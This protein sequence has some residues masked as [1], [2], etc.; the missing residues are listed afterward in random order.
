[1]DSFQSSPSY[2]DSDDSKAQIQHERQFVL[3]MIVHKYKPN[4]TYILVK[5]E[6]TVNKNNNIVLGLITTIIF[7]HF[8]IENLM[9]QTPRYTYMQQVLPGLF[10]GSAV[11]AHRLLANELSKA[12][13]ADI[14][15]VGKTNSNRKDRCP[16][17]RYHFVELKDQKNE[18][19]TVCFRRCF[20][21]MDKR[22]N[23]KNKRILIHCERGVSRSPSIVMAYLIQSKVVDSFEQALEYI[24]AIRPKV[25]PLQEFRNQIIEWDKNREY[26]NKQNIN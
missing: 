18:D 22:L 15:D 23:G 1:M 26:Q 7:L 5:I 9:T 25:D 11:A 20:N 19:I 3:M 16:G 17:I 21:I 4:K 2:L 10:L 13:I 8:S 12:G 24:K 6:A 14:I